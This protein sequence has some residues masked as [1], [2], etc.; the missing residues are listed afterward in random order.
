MNTLYIDLETYSSTDIKA[1]VYRYSEDPTFEIMMAAYSVDGKTVEIAIGEEAIGNIPNLF[2]H[3]VRKVAHNA[4]FERV[5]LSRLSAAGLQDGDFLDPVEWY[6]TMVI[7]AEHGYPQSLENLG[8]AMGGEKKSQAGTRLINLFC[9]PDKK[10]KRATALDYPEEWQ[11]FLDYCVQDVRTLIDIEKRLPAWPTE[12][13]R[14]AWI[15]D[16]RI[17]D[18]GIKLDVE[19]AQAAIS[20]ADDNRMLA[21]LEIS[22][23]TGVANP[24][25]PSQMLKY[26]KSAG[27]DIFNMQAETIEEL[28]L[29]PDLT[30]T[31]RKVLE[32][33]QELALVASKKFTAALASVNSDGRLR[34]NFRFFGAHTGR[35]SSQGLQFHN[36]P[37]LSFETDTQADAAILDLMLGADISPVELKAMVRSM[38]VGPFTVVDYSAIEARVIAWL[39][40]EGWALDAFARGRDIYMETAERMGGMT[41]R[42][43]KVAVLAL[44]YN[45]GINSLRAMGAEGNDDSLQVLVNQWRWANPNIVKFWQTM[46]EAFRSG[47]AVGDHMQVEA[48]GGTRFL[49]LP[50]GRAITYHGV[51]FEFAETPY[52]PKR[53]PSF[54]DPR[55]NQRVKTYGGRLTENVTQAVARD[56]L[57][58]AIVRLQGAGYKVAG[59]VHDEILVEGEHDLA[60]ITRIMTQQPSWAEGLPLDGAGF[61]CSRYRK[62]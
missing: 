20:V 21:E 8:K 46:G 26:L 29:L 12:A 54:I 36:L 40:G 2:N 14:Q 60:E 1:G 13:E 53:Q 42:E 45:G 55:I 10:G 28:L 27:L 11:E 48:D 52:G 35:W 44:G 6:D 3:R 24:S 56:I 38:F 9:Q 16:Q 18:L 47:G 51:K 39:A 57:S 50:S 31:V 4:Q 62:G 49:R 7:A 33:R 23:L 17:N 22:F 41:R 30:P 32:L 5:C 19:M 61:N 15:A 34:G 25:S 58:E 59:H 37:R 43:G